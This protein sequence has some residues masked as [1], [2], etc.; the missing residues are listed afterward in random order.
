MNKRRPH[1]SSIE[2]IIVHREGEEEV[3]DKKN[4]GQADTNSK[5]KESVK[6]INVR[7]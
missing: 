5:Q 6:V 1:K 7:I 2:G 4:V 3:S